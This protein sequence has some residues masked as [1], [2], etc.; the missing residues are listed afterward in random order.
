[1]KRLEPTAQQSFGDLSWA[2][3]HCGALAKRVTLP[4]CSRCGADPTAER[5]DETALTPPA[6]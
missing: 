1:M 6:P 2:I 3:L 4:R 5:R